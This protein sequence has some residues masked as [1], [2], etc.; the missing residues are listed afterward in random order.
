MSPRL[1]SKE[2]I[3]IETHCDWEGHVIEQL[4]RTKEQSCEKAQPSQ[5]IHLGY[6]Y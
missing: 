5:N 4:Q 6:T 1:K 2:K 3:Y